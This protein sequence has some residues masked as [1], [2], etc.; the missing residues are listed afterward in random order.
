ML[1]WDLHGLREGFGGAEGTTGDDWELH[2]L[3]A[4]QELF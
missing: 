1:G 4:E 2:H 3:P